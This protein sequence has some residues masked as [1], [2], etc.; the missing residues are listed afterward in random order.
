MQTPRRP[1]PLVARDLKAHPGLAG[2]LTLTGNTTAGTEAA[3]KTA[4]QTGTVKLA[5]FEASPLPMTG[6]DTGGDPATVAREPAVEGA[7]A[8]DQAVSAVAEKQVQPR[9]STPMVAITPQNMNTAAIKPYIYHGVCTSSLRGY[10]FALAPAG[11]GR[12]KRHRVPPHPVP[13]PGRARSA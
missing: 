13:A 12:A 4:G 7:E 2:V 5:T 11:T 6:L 10:M 9:V 3:L 8:V 1:P